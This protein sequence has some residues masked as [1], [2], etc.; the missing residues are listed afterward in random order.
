MF[1][2]NG[3]D[4]TTFDTSKNVAVHPLFVDLSTSRV[5]LWHEHVRFSPLGKV[6]RGIM[7]HEDFWYFWYFSNIKKRVPKTGTFRTVSNSNKLYLHWNR[8]WNF[9]FFYF[10][11]SFLSFPFSLPS[12]SPTTKSFSFSRNER[13]RKNW[14][15]TLPLL[16]IVLLLSLSLSLSMYFFFSLS[17]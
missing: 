3:S 15:L 16:P 4:V 2:K 14:N 12:L 5:V 17:L 11:L 9:F 1:E 10:F 7:I 13:R 6:K 8:V